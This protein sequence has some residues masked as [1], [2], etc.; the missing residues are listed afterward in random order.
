MKDCKLAE[1]LMPLYAD[2]LTSPET[3]EWLEAHLA[4]CPECRAMW[5]RCAA[6]LS[7]TVTIDETQVRKTM[8]RDAWRMTWDGTK[9]FVLISLFPILVLLGIV[10]YAAWSFGEFAPV[11]YTAT[12]Y[13]EVFG[14]TMTVDILDRD[15]VGPMYGGAG[16]IIRIRQEYSFTQPDTDNW[17]T[18][19]E[20]VEIDIAPN[21]TFKLFTATMPDGRTDYFIIAYHYELGETEGWIKTRL[22]PAQP[23]K[24]RFENCQDGLTAILTQYCRENPEIAQDWNEIDFTFHRWSADS[25]AVEFF[26][27]TDTGQI[28][29]VRYS[30]EGQESKGLG[31]MGYATA[32]VAG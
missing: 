16:S 25:M 17:E 4:A 14:G 3:N 2:E 27:M 15:Q 12:A 8:M 31:S 13:S 32:Q 18:C 29:T 7:Q 5:N 22:Y 6:P 11:E 24:V 26:Y 23:E 21:G 30:M 19:W 20:N 9:R 1:D 28:G 10:F